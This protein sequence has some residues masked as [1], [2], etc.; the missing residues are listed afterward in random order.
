M[1]P[2]P[3]ILGAQ[4]P[5]THAARA[6][7]RTN[8]LLYCNQTAT[9]NCSD[10]PALE[11]RA[12]RLFVLIQ[13]ITSFVCGLIFCPC[14]RRFLISPSVDVQS[15]ARSLSLPF[16]Q[17]FPARG[18]SGIRPLHKFLGLLI[19]VGLLVGCVSGAQV[20]FTTGKES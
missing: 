13:P 10:T 16:S 14:R 12:A 19:V 3:P 8:H 2:D 1:A 6:S 17:K 5:K 11:L 18:Q 4:S 9:L 15:S 20:S 7:W